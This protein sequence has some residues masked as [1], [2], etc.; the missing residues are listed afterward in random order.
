[1]NSSVTIFPDLPSRKQ[2]TSPSKSIA[3]AL[4]PSEIDS[5]RQDKRNTVAKVREHLKTVPLKLSI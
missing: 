2:D 1:M 4:T 3:R 5:L